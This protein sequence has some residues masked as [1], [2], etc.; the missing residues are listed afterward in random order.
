MEQRLHKRLLITV[1]LILAAAP[2]LADVVFDA[3]AKPAPAAAI[4]SFI[5]GRSWKWGPDTGLYF[6]P[7]GSLVGAAKGAPG[8]MAGHGTW[9]AKDGGLCFDI[10]WATKSNPKVKNEANCTKL[11]QGPGDL[12]GSKAKDVI[13]F[14]NYNKPGY[15]WAIADGKVWKDFPKGDKISK[16]ADKIMK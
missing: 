15:Y 1:A 10:T 8:M 3:S 14:A 12:G 6:S 2:V 7:D 16:S 4:K 13:G 9:S 11:L 5:S